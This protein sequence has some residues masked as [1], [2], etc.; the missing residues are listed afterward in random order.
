MLEYD[1]E[2]LKKQRLCK[3]T[4]TYCYQVFMDVTG[5]ID[6]GISIIAAHLAA[7]TEKNR[8]MRKDI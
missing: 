1:N 6:K 5:K 4:G 3:T 7:K 8:R 2:V